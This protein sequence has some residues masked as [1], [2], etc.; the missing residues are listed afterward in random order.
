MTSNQFSEI[1][2]D[3][4][5]LLAP[6]TT[7]V[8]AIVVL[9]GLLMSW[10]QRGSE[11]QHIWRVALIAVALLVVVDSTGIAHWILAS[12]RI[13]LNRSTQSPSSDW[14]VAQESTA[15]FTRIAPA[16][17]IWPAAIW[18]I[19]AALVLG[20]L[21]WV[22]ARLRRLGRRLPPMTSPAVLKK[23]RILSA[24]IGVAAPRVVTCPRL[25]SPVVIGCR[26]PRLVLPENFV[27]KFD[28][29]CQSAVL[30]HELGHVAAGDAR[31]QLLVES[32][33]AVL[34]WHPAIWWAR[35]QIARAAERAADETTLHIHDGPCLLAQSLV[36]LGWQLVG[37]PIYG[38][39]AAVG[40]RSELAARVEQLLRLDHSE[41]P[42]TMK[43]VGAF[44]CIAALAFAVVVSVGSSWSF[45]AEAGGD[46]LSRLWLTTS[47]SWSPES[48]AARTVPPPSTHPEAVAIATLSLT[49]EQT[50]QFWNLHAQLEVATA[51]MHRLPSGKIARGLEINRQWIGGL[52]AIFTEEQFAGYCRYWES[53]TPRRMLA[54]RIS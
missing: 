53:R 35:R 3:W 13:A 29:D 10:R 5:A 54:R 9:A 23:V 19:G 4:M 22:H 11:R 31:W 1:L 24:R 44:G 49:A 36:T 46:L 17:S 32:L 28:P 37:R 8:A 43:S 20:R 26:K 52:K 6:V 33:T 48:I 41:R 42:R 21:C 27:E 7:G 12:A 2:W 30:A 51:E 47:Q 25:R 34:W 39:H 14:I 45:A 15:L 40:L 50:E 38:S 18:L 16:A